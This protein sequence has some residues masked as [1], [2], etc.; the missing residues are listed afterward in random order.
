[1]VVRVKV[2][3]IRVRAVNQAT[4]SPEGEYVLY[5][6]IASRR[7]GYNF[8]LQ[9]A[10]ELADELGKPLVILEALRVGYRWAS[11]RLHGFVLDGMRENARAFADAPVR[12]HAYVEGEA[13]EGR[14][15]LEALAAGAA[16]V[17]SDYFPCFFLPR[18]LLAAAKKLSVRLEAVDGNGLL[19]ISAAQTDF[20]TAFA[21]RR[22]LQK[23]LRPH[24]DAASLPLADPFA[25][26]KLKSPVE[27]PSAL[28]RRWPF[29]SEALLAR[30][31]TALAKLPIDHSVGPVALRGG[32]AI[33]DDVLHHFLD[34]N[35]ERYGEGRNHP[36]DQA[37]SGLS[38]YLHFGHIS[39][40]QVFAEIVAREEWTTERLAKTTSGKREGW[41]NMSA[42]SEAFLD[43][44]V[45]WRELGY[46]HCTRHRSDYDRYESLPAWA[47]ASLEKHE[48]DPRK[49]EYTLAE[50]A[51]SRTHDEVWN[52]AQTEL[53]EEGRMHNYLRM[54]WGKKILEWSRTPRVALE[55][56]IELNN[57][58]AIDG[59]N[60]N[61]YSG[62]FWTLGRYDRPW[63]PERPIFGVIRYM[64]SDNT[65]KKLHLKNYL[66]RYRGRAT[67]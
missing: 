24:L 46:N 48:G 38:P 49:Y 32:S 64:S 36:D 14:G 66:V 60:P 2:P 37:A 12:Y 26:A 11:D 54:L 30:E 44:I 3:D 42:P 43:E 13:G 7:R 35:L 31:P 1:M 6:M 29:A 55:H 57:R 4:V 62:I 59:R 21:F 63:A 9:R 50:L 20:A 61:S 25:H 8:G 58:F 10:V 67:S 22:F 52:A 33:A 28:L 53:R 65:K 17:V 40:H 19:P 41:W 16:V 18:M 56:M 39:V 5:W 34:D 27:L 15:L 47:R 45:T 51:E 23:N